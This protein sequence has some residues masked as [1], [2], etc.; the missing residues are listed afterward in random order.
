MQTA[1]PWLNPPSEAPRPPRVDEKQATAPVGMR[2][3]TRICPQCAQE[4]AFEYPEAATRW[5]QNCPNCAQSIAMELVNGR[6]CLVH[7]AR[8]RRVVERL[9]PGERRRRFY[10]VRCHGCD[11]WLMVAGEELDAG[12]ACPV[13]G[14]E[15]RLRVADGEVCYESEPRV[16]GMV[17]LSCERVIEISGYVNDPA[18]LFVT[19]AG[20]A[21]AAGRGDGAALSVGR[22][23]GAVA[24]GHEERLALADARREMKLL[25][26]RD[27]ASRLALRQVADERDAANRRLERAEGELTRIRAERDAALATLEATRRDGVEARETLRREQRERMMMEEALAT[28]QERVEGLEAE[29]RRLIQLLEEESEAV[30]SATSGNLLPGPESEDRGTMTPDEAWYCPEGREEALIPAWDELGLARR[31]LGIR[32]ELTVERIQWAYRTRVKSYHPDR[33]ASMGVALRALAHEKMREINRAY[34]I[35]M[36]AHGHG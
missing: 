11:A 36:R 18:S 35:L 24:S 10:R 32:G 22:G 16:G 19:G 34:G 29:R 15:H 25:R 4:V 7:E 8:G 30:E 14:L 31:V 27:V 1:N 9:G 33:L 26:E 23:S 6:R 17:V 28:S 21:A 20:G 12:R 3:L 5:Q 2:L 13:C